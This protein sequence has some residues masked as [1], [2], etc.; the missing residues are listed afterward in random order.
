MKDYT[1]RNN[2]AMDEVMRTL[3]FEDKI[4][5][6]FCIEV[7]LNPQMTDEQLADLKELALR[8]DEW[9]DEDEE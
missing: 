5:I 7:E 1:K 6:W 3:G 2:E 9:D 8:D 4:T